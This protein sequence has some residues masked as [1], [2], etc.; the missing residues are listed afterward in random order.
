MKRGMTLTA[1][2]IML[3]ATL[4]WTADAWARVG[5]GGSSGI[6]ESH[7]E[8]LYSRARGGGDRGRSSVA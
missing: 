7:G 3:L 8:N 2:L 1:I 5:G 4:L 6:R